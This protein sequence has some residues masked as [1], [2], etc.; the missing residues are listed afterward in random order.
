VGLDAGEAV[1]EPCLGIDVV[2]ASGLDQRD[3]DGGAF[4]ATVRSG[5]Q[6]CR[7]PKARP[8]RARSAALLKGMVSMASFGDLKK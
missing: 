5:E 2:E 4:G 6:P 3:H 8:L 7:L 1:G